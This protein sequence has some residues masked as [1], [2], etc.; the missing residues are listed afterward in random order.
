MNMLGTGLVV[1]RRLRREERA[2]WSRPSFA[3]PRS[4]GPR[5]PRTSRAPPTRWSTLAENEPAKEVLVKQLTLAIPLLDRAA[6]GVNT[7]AKWTETISLMS[8]YAEL[9]D[10][11]A[12]SK[13][14]DSA[15][16]GK[17]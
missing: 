7:E 5:R 1:Q 6:P 10:A 11:G 13:Y 15:Y 9:K 2:T 16:A 17:G 4:R 3:P 12:P 8:Q 14:W